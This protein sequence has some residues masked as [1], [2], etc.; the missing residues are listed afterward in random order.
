MPKIT[1]LTAADIEQLHR[2]VEAYLG[3]VEAFRAEDHEPAYADDEWLWR[4]GH[5]RAGS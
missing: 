3:A 1:Q 5:L 2:E 4:L